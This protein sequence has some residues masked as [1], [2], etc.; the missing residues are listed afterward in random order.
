[1]VT[2]EKQLLPRVS[3]TQVVPRDAQDMGGMLAHGESPCSCREAERQIIMFLL[4]I[5]GVSALRGE[6]NL[7][8]LMQLPVVLPQNGREK[9]C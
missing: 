3:D 6:K 7:D 8:M 5:G 1:M 2:I 4:E 9:R